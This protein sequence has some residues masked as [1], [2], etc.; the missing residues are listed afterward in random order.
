VL[1]AWFSTW[2]GAALR[3]ARQSL[4]L[5]KLGEVYYN[6]TSHFVSVE[7]E[8]CYDVPQE[9]VV[10]GNDIVYENHITGVTPVCKF[11][12]TNDAAFNVLYSFSFPDEWD[13]GYGPCLSV[14][15]MLA[16]ILWF[17]T[18]ADSG[19]LVVDILAANGRH[20]THPM[21]R[22][23]WAFTEGLLATALLSA[24][25]SNALSAVQ[26]TSIVC[27]LPYTLL[28]LYLLQSIY[29]MCEQALDEEQILFMTPKR[30]FIMPVYGGIFNIFEYI[31][32]LG[33]VHQSR[34]ILGIDLP[35]AFQTTECLMSLFLPFVPLQD[36]VFTMYPKPGSQ[37]TN[38]LLLLFFTGLFLFWVSCLLVAI[39]IDPSLIY[40]GIAAYTVCSCLLGNLKYT[41]RQRRRL[42]GNLIGDLLSSFLLYPQVITQIRIELIEY[43]AQQ[44]VE[45]K[46]AKRNRKR[47]SKRKT[48]SRVSS[49]NCL[50]D[51]EGEQT[52]TS[53]RSQQSKSRRKGRVQSSNDSV[54]TSGNTRN[55]AND[56][57]ER[58]EGTPSIDKCIEE[59]KERA[60]VVLNSSNHDK[61]SA[62]RLD[63]NNAE[64]ESKQTA[65][66][67]QLLKHHSA[68]D[69]RSGLRARMEEKT[70]HR[71]HPISVD[72]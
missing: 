60:P 65:K 49:S 68:T 15:F 71:R 19:S 30:Q 45:S 39:T 4:E 67:E 55:S 17:A 10:I 53:T 48:K 22:L 34:V 21:Q 32:S 2:G 72:V 1:V 6:D 47:T 51:A 52:V 27:G 5:E 35:S 54:S 36:I 66:R 11:Y 16:I 46:K 8:Y 12:S 62:R 9:D 28:L 7:N 42:H 13:D 23:F 63:V 37:K 31:A 20:D 3:Q 18:S 64:E 29:E 24:G 69:I 44:V 40:W 38:I 56:H 14:L 33:Q 26:A 43:G 25:G 70:R 57:N 58:K 50:D 41:V 59:Q 61:S